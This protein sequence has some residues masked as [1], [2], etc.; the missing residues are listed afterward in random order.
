MFQGM[1]LQTTAREEILAIMEKFLLKTLFKI[2]KN[3]KNPKPDID[4]V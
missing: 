1:G 3:N 4:T 2:F